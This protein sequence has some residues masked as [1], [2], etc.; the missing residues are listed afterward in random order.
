MSRRKS[1]EGAPDSG[2]DPSAPKFLLPAHRIP[3][4]CGMCRKEIAWSPELGRWLD[5]ERA[6]G[7][8]GQTPQVHE[9]L[10]TCGAAPSPREWVPPPRPA[11]T[12]PAAP[13]PA[14]HVGLSDDDMPEWL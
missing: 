6:G 8:K 1:A 7:P 14:V 2:A 12:A 3:V 11:D 5:L 9:H 4:V 13:E 10:R